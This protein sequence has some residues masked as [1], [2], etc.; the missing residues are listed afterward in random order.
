MSFFREK[1]L[2]P[3]SIPP[4]IYKALRWEIQSAV[5]LRNIYFLYTHIN[6]LILLRNYSAVH[7]KL[8]TCTGTALQMLA[9]TFPGFLSGILNCCPQT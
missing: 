3:E 9:E 6:N 2:F 4:L 5:G 7:N 8:P 1:N